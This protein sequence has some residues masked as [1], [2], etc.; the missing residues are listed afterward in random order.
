MEEALS[1]LS[2]GGLGIYLE[3]KDISDHSGAP[4]NEVENEFVEKVVKVVDDLKINDKV[5]FASFRYDYIKKIKNENPDSKIL[6]N[7]GLGDADV[8]LKDYPADYY[9]LNIDT[10]LPDTMTKLLKGGAIPYVYTANTP[11]QIHKVYDLGVCGIVTNDPK[12]A[13][14]ILSNILRKRF[15]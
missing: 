14:A 13:N 8:L 6:C 15:E 3:L 12:L 4:M 7:T 10:I 5:I 1:L 9:G 2:E 11:R